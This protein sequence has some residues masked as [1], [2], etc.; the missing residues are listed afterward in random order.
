M[1]QEDEE[2]E[3]NNCSVMQFC[4]LFLACYKDLKYITDSVSLVEA[5]AF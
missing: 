1:P 5:L 3:E 2:S 4:R